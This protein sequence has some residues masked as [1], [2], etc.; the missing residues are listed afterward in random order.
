MKTVQPTIEMVAKAAGVSKMTVSR[1][2]NHPEKVNPETLNLIMETMKKL[3]YR[4]RFVARVLAGGKSRTIGFLVKSNEDFIIS[5]FY[6]ECIRAAVEWLKTQN[7]RSVIFNLLDSQGKSLFVDYMNSGL[8]DGLIVFEGIYERELLETLKINSI[9]SILV[10]ENLMKEY[11]F[12]TVSSDNYGGANKAVEHLIKTGCS[13]IVYVTGMGEKPSY[14]HR[15]KAY[16]DTLKKYK[17]SYCKIVETPVSINGGKKAVE[18]LL[19]EGEDFDGL[20]CFSDLIAIGA[21]RALYENRV[22]VPSEVKVVGFDNIRLSRDFV[23]SLTTVAQ[24]MHLMGELASNMLL[25]ILSGKKAK[26]KNILL[27]TELIVRESA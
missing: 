13:R 4:P 18:K 10:G 23:P 20:F 22:K 3:N 9:P 7:Y 16:I 17:I 11:D 24:N 25:R 19:K 27:S 14:L 15:K 6:G 12:V 26:Q 1:A 21:L 5:P 8:L 2:I